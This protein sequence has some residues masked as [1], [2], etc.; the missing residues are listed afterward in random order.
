MQVKENQVDVWGN[1]K[2]HEAWEEYFQFSDVHQQF[3]IK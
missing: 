3:F 2:S 1:K